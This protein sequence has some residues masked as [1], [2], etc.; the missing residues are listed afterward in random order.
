M[1]I[2]AHRPINPKIVSINL[3]WMNLSFTV[4]QVEFREI[5]TS[6]QIAGGQKGDRSAA[7]R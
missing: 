7:P 3:A 5:L 2:A 1:E 6:G 4:P